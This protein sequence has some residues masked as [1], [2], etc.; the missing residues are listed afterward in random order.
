VARQQ[1]ERLRATLAYITN[2]RADTFASS[3]QKLDDLAALE[4]LRLNQDTAATILALPD[5]RW[6][7]IEQET[8]TV[9]ERVM[10]NSI[11]PEGLEEAR[12]RVPAMV[13]LSL[14]ENQAEIVAEMVSAYVAPNSQY[15]E[16]LT[17]AA[18]QAAREAAPPVSRSFVAGQT[19]VLRGQV[20]S[21]ADVEALYKLGLMRTGFE[22]QNLISPALLSLL[23]IT[24]LMIYLRRERADISRNMRNLLLIVVIFLLFLY[25]GRF[26]IPSHAVIPYV[27]PIAAFS[28]A[29][30]A[31]FGAQLALVSTL[32]LAI[33]VAY[34]FP[35]AL[36]LTLFYSVG[37]LFGT[38][39]LGRARKMTSFFWAGLTVAITGV[40][41]VLIYRLPSQ[42]T[43]LSGLM[44]LS[45]AAMLNGLA[46]ASLAVVIQSLLAQFLGTVTPLQLVDLTR[47]DQPL[48]SKLMRDAPGT[49]QHSLQLANLVEQ[50]AEQV[51]A[52]PLLTRVGALYHDIGKTMN[53]IYF[54]ENQLPGYEN[55][56]ETLTP[57]ESAQIIIRHVQDGLELGRKHRLPRRILDFI[58]EHHGTLITGFQYARAVEAAGGDSS[59][60]DIEKFRY[61]GPRPQSRETAILMLA[62]GSEARVR[63][64]RPADEGELRRL[65]RGVI[66]DRMAKGQLD[67]TRLTLRDLNIILESFTTTLRGIYHPRLKYPKLEAL[68]ALDAVT[69]PL[70]RKKTEAEVETPGNAPS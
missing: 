37:G 58:L 50:A 39:A 24:F 28:M 70:S 68:E 11:R 59:K 21:A 44:T 51:G 8:I 65:I 67:S 7:E 34:G 61:P 25:A 17:E 4:D 9:L 32:P 48:L 30:T 41:I 14:P 56:H 23:L 2:V 10:S 27:F 6:Q 36:E 63:A 54:I 55:P 15:S 29:I 18:R 57:E 49:Y 5:T 22:W 35:N 47:P 42:S 45:G 69:T 16:S 60:V 33:L 62:D 19:V 64:E 1:L 3:Q 66:E 12:N 38:L 31:L 40:L 43:D 26:T 52:D 46:S 53:A 13:S 20:L